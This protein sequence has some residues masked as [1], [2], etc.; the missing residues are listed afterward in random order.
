MADFEEMDHKIK[1]LKEDKT[2]SDMISQFEREEKEAG[3]ENAGQDEEIRTVTS[4]KK[5]KLDKVLGRGAFGTVYMGV[6]K[7]KKYAVKQIDKNAVIT[8][9]LGGDEKRY[10]TMRDREI[11]VSKLV[12]DI[13]YCINFYAYFEEDGVENFVYELCTGGDLTSLLSK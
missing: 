5:F 6:F 12:F 11:L 9:L 4:L 10:I 8:Q 7:G 1:N 13:K 3:E 2:L